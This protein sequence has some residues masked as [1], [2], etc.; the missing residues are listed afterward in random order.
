LFEVQNNFGNVLA[1]FNSSGGLVLGLSTLTSNATVSRSIALPD[2]DGVVCLSGSA[3]CTFLTYATGSFVTDASTNNTIAINKTGAS[4]NIIALQKNGGAVFTVANTGS[5]QIQSTDS[6]A[7]DVRNV[8]GTSFFSVNTSTGAVQIGSSTADGVG[9][10]FV[11]DTKNTAGDPTGVNGG[12]YY[13]SV[14]GKSRCFEDGRWVDCIPSRVQDDTTLTIATN[15]INVSIPD[16]SVSLTCRLESPGVSTANLVYLRFNNI[17]AGN[18]YAYNTLLN[19]TGANNNTSTVSSA[20]ANQIA[21]SGTTTISGSSNFE[22][23]ISNY[24]SNN[25]A[26]SWFGSRDAAGIP[27]RLNGSGVYLNTSGA[28]TSVQ[29]VTSAGNFNA[30]TRAWCEAR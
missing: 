30:G 5:L 19:T 6:L 29:F 17:A 21:I 13:N 10:L 16:D 9:V 20:G 15:T 14:L 24:A 22:V 11:L 12:M 2:E 26:V 23:T 7:L 25:K 28:I 1:G 4:G 8:G 18:P 3:A 27:Q